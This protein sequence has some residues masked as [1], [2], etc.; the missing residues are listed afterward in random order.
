MIGFNNAMLREMYIEYAT[1]C[2][3]LVSDPDILKAFT[4]CPVKDDHK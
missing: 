1:P 3:R 4:E 2:D